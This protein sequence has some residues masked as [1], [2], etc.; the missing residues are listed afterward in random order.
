[1][2][3]TKDNFIWKIITNEQAEALFN[4]DCIEIYRLY[5][6]G[7]EALIDHVHQIDDA[8]SDCDLLALEV[9]HYI[10]D[11]SGFINDNILQQAI[12]KWG[13]DSQI[14]IIQEEAIELALAII[15][16][17]RK[18]GDKQKKIDNI[19]DELANNKIINRLSHLI[20][21]SDAINARVDYKMKRLVERLK[22]DNYEL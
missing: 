22:N 14:E 16:S 10:Q 3:I 1:M 4:T 11:Q 19:I 9:G 13:T 15:K 18:S 12:D 17:K 20:Y 7:S 2:K 6:D 21:S 5:E 8:F